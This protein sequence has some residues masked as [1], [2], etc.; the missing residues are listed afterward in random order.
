MTVDPLFTDVGMKVRQ[1]GSIARPPRGERFFAKR[2]FA[3]G[4]QRRRPDGS[5]TS[6]EVEHSAPVLGAAQSLLIDM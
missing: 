2:P 6:G 5:V 1:G 4:L 3:L